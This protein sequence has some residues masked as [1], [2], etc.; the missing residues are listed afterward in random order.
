MRKIMALGL[1]LILAT[2][3]LVAYVLLQER[4]W[5][6]PERDGANGVAIAA[7]GSTY[8]TGSTRSFGAGGDD[9][10]LLKY[11]ATGA[12]LWQ[13]TYGTAPDTLNSGEE[14]GIAVAVAPDNSGVLMLGNYR[15]GNIFL[16]KFSPA[17]SFLWDRTWGPPNSASASGIA[18]AANGTIYVAGGTSS[19]G[20]GGTDAF[21]LSLTPAG[22]LN[23]QRTWGGENFDIARDVAVATDGSIYIS[24]E[25]Q[26]TANSALLVKFAASGAVVWQREWG[27]VGRTG[28][29]ND[30][31]MSGGGVAA[32]PGGGA[33]VV[34][35]TTGAGFDPNLVA[36]Q[37]DAAGNFAWVRVGGPGFGAAQDVA[38]GP[39]GN[40]QITGNVL[41][42]GGDSG[43]NAFVWTLSGAGKAADAAIWGGT[44]LFEAERGASI[45]VAPDGSIVVVGSAGASPYAFTRGSKNAKAPAT[46]LA[47]IAGTVTTPAG[48]IADPTAIVN[49]PV[50]STSFAGA[51]DA[52]VLRVR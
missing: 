24:G 44:D 12:L 5:G 48:A 13:R 43:A 20:A 41:T 33:Y 14:A 16:A 49:I 37:F 19:F 11:D 10:F 47:A 7:D 22:A 18:T 36:A 4:T 21:L 25:T 9:A 40:V 26:F 15:D 17:G 29:P 23:W 27:L 45:A 28:I 30:D 50:G 51:S 2:V 31:V 35:S 52:F 32:A 34:G 42:D 39:G 8:V 1:T 6:G 38:V 3:P 46:F